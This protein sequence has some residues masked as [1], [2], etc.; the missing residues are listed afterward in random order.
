MKR[1]LLLLIHF[2]R[3]FISPLKP[4]TCRFYPTCSLYAV[5]AIEKYGAFKGS[6]LA[7]KRILKCHPFHKGGYDPVE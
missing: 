7:V 1:I 6:Y 3:R 5:Q 2:Y 4:P